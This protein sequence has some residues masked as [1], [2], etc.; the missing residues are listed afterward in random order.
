MAALDLWVREVHRNQ[1]AFAARATGYLW[2]GKSEFQSLDVVDT[3]AFGRVLLLD[4]LFMTTE[5]DEFI[6]HEMVSHT[7]LFTHPHPRRVLVI[8]GGDGG[9]AR[10]AAKHPSVERVDLVEIDRLV[11]EKSREFLPTI[12][13]G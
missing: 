2:S 10:E 12:A 3:E 8:G 6:Y 5:K 13:C 1:I 7:P 11:V 4:G 9:T